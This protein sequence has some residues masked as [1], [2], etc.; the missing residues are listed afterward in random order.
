MEQLFLFA[1]RLEL[2]VGDPSVLGS[3]KI[4]WRRGPTFDQPIDEL[5]SLSSSFG[6]IVIA[7]FADA[8]LVL[9]E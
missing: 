1:L 5:L 7:Y 3:V 6:A 4:L 8:F 2:L 9:S